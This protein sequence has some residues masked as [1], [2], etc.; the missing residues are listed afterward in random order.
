MWGDS[1]LLA[2]LAFFGASFAG[3]ATQLR[4]GNALTRRA[5]ASA[6]LNSGLIGSIIALLGYRTFAEDLPYLMG[7]SLLAGI[8]GATILDFAL[9][10]LKRRMG[11]IIRIEQDKGE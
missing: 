2:A 10:L 7:M 9:L 3:L 6:M 11:I 1:L 5:V 4:S 8:G